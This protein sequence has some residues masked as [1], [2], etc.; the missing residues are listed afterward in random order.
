MKEPKG[1]QIREIASALARL[2]N[3]A[4]IEAFLKAILTPA[5]LREVAGR[6]QL[7]E[8]LHQGHSQ[9]KIADFLGM[10]LCKITRGS[11][12]LKQPGSILKRIFDENLNQD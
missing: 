4:D 8:M 2:E 5:E 12:E 3:P 7:V 6:W 9:R 10:S 1:I 11:R